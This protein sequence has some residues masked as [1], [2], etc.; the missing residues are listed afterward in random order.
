MPEL[1]FNTRLEDG[2][3]QDVSFKD[4]PPVKREI[5]SDP[6]YW[7]MDEYI[8]GKQTMR[9]ARV[10]AICYDGLTLWHNQSQEIDPP[11]RTA[12]IRDQVQQVVQ[13]FPDM[14][15]KLHEMNPVLTRVGA[16]LTWDEAVGA[17]SAP[18]RACPIGWKRGDPVVQE[19]SHDGTMAVNR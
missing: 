3:L 8:G 18:Q 13:R 16:T 14:A 2:Q 4:Y 11:Q 6:G 17:P 1:I 15:A 10:Y 7:Q 12:L 5:L 19:R 9:I